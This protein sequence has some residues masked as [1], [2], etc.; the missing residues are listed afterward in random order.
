M[1]ESPPSSQ[2]FESDHKHNTDGARAHEIPLVAEAPSAVLE[3]GSLDPVYE[4][5]AKV[6]NKAIQDIGMGKY[7]WQVSI[8]VINAS[9]MMIIADTLFSSSLLSASDGH[10]ITFGLLLHH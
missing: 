8:H 7:Q 4:A 5:K 6:L 9:I 2:K 10:Q 1:A 3:E